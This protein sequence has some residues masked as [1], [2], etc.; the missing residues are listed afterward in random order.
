ML[1]NDDYEQL[2]IIS[3]KIAELENERLNPSVI[4]LPD[5]SSL[6][7]MNVIWGIPVKV[8]KSRETINPIIV[9]YDNVV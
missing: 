1:Q 6:K 3:N 8:Y 2:S 5:N 7:C 9:C 4:I